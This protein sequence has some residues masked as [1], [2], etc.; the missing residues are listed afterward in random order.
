MTSTGETKAREALSTDLGARGDGDDV[1]SSLRRTYPRGFSHLERTIADAAAAGPVGLPRLADIEIHADR[2]RLTGFADGAAAETAFDVTRITP[3]GGVFDFVLDPDRQA[4]FLLG[5]GQEGDGPAHAVREHLFGLLRPYYWLVEGAKE[6]GADLLEAGI[7]GIR[8][9]L[10]GVLDRTEVAVVHRWVRAAIQA[11]SQDQ[12]AG[13]SEFA[14]NLRRASVELRRTGA[15]PGLQR[16]LADAAQV[17]TR[18]RHGVHPVLAMRRVPRGRRSCGAWAPTTPSCGRQALMNPGFARYTAAHSISADVL[19]TAGPDSLLDLVGQLREFEFFT[20]F[21]AGTREARRVR[22]HRPG[23]GGGGTG[24]GGDRAG[25][26]AGVD[27]ARALPVP[28]ERIPVLPGGVAPDGSERPGLPAERGAGRQLAGFFPG[29]G[30]RAFY[31]DLGRGLLDSG[32][33]EVTGIYE[34]AARALG[35]PAS[36]ERLVMDAG[37]LPAGRLAAQ[38]FI[39]AALLVHS[40]AVEAHLRAG[41]ADGEVPLRFVAYTG[42]S[43]GIITAAVAAGALSVGDGVK[44]GRAFTPLVLTA[45]DG[46]GPEDPLARRWRRTCPNPCAAGVW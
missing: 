6:P 25:H 36:R 43:F 17:A 23:S 37:N 18:L 30:S 35:F 31:Q 32:V 33:P 34:E 38:G 41:A 2:L 21:L 40:L 19:A 46:V 14:Q 3:P 20:I 42:E 24:A 9:F 27:K 22:R 26:P 29:L 28:D 12:E 16:T 10:T 44:L 7:P 11:M 1:V 4:I 45:A 13:A 8:E 5:G 39:G 15:D